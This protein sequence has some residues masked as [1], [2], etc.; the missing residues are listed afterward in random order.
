MGASRFPGKPLKEVLGKPLLFY[1]IERLKRVS[2]ADQIVV[3]TTLHERDDAIVEFCHRMNVDVFRGSEN[4]VLERYYLAAKQFHADV[5]VRITG[6]CP[7][8]DPEIVDR[9]IQY[10]LINKFDYVSNS[11][12]RTYPRGMDVEVLSF[13]SLEKARK[14]AKAEPEREHVTLFVYRHPEMFTL[15]N[16]ANEKDES[17]HRWTVDTAEDFELVRNFIE[18]LYPKKPT[19]LMSD[20]LNEIKA[21]PDWFYINSHIQQKSV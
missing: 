9:V 7:L 2:H 1:Q 6:D 11:L 15:G 13:K 18:S 4:D 12:V 14:L 3:A 5:V 8:I 17:R 21:H 19:F 10:F 20:L 16:V